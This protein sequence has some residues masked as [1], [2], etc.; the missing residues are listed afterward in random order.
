M[1]I[2]LRKK[3]KPMKTKHLLYIPIILS[4]GWLGADLNFQPMVG[5][6]LAMIVL[7]F[8]VQLLIKKN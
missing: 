2:C 5:D 7:E 4:L 3:L 6:W 8:C 1:D